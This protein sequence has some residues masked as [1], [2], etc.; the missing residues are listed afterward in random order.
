[1]RN[2]EKRWEIL[3]NPERGVRIGATGSYQAKLVSRS[4][5]RLVTVGYGY[6]RFG[7]VWSGFPRFAA[8]REDEAVE[9]GG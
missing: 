5:L 8:V 3:R 2:R 7:A 6:M 1:V 4:Y 9:E